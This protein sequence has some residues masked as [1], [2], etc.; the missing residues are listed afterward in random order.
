MNERR[1]RAHSVLVRTRDILTERLTER[2]LEDEQEILD[3]ARGVDYMDD[4]SRLYESVGSKLGQIN[5]MIANLPVD[6]A[7]QPNPP[8][9]KQP[10]G[11]KIPSSVPAAATPDEPRTFAT[12]GK[13]IASNQ[14]EAAAQ[15]LSELL[16]ISPTLALHSANCFSQQFHSDPHMIQ[17]TM[18]LRAELFAANTNN[19]LVILDECFGLQGIEAVQVVQH[20]LS[21]V[22]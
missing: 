10:T 13:Q 9:V 22:A 18:Q 20:L 3:D 4:I 21:Q 16:A 2:I 12:F 6:A 11:V 7:P 1:R 14:I 19:C 15:T 5:L 17:K 8:M